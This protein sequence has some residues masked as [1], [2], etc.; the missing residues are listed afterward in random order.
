MSPNSSCFAIVYLSVVCYKCQNVILNMNFNIVLFIYGYLGLIKDITFFSIEKIV[1]T[2][3]KW[4][5]FT[6]GQIL[7][8][9][10]Q[11]LLRA[12]P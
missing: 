1:F 3:N 8:L 5:L 6:Q 7:K 4:T 2:T 9:L 10:F 11:Y 12:K